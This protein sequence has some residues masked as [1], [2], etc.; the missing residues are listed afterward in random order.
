M[1]NESKVVI[2]IHFSYLTIFFSHG[3]SSDLMQ[4]NSKHG[5]GILGELLVVS[6]QTLLSL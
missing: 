1:N 6:L 5:L 2:V 4:E 3:K